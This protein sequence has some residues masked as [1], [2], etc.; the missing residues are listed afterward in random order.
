M[1]LEDNLHEVCS[2]PCKNCATLMQ[3]PFAMNVHGLAAA[4]A[5]RSSV[6]RAAESYQ[7]PMTQELKVVLPWGGEGFV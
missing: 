6:G 4:I 3:E 2:A 7:L 1:P 5:S